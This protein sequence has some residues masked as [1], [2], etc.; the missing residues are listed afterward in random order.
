MLP[1]DKWVRCVKIKPRHGGNA[2]LELRVLGWMHRRNVAA[3]A[4]DDDEEEVVVVDVVMVAVAV[5]ADNV[6]IAFAASEAN[7]PTPLNAPQAIPAT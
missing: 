6:A 2:R 5:A 7:P 1:S 3:A 4:H